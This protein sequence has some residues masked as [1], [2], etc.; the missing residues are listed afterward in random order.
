MSY[1]YNISYVLSQDQNSELLIDFVK[2]DNHVRLYST[3]I[4]LT[5]SVTTFYVGG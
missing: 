5:S 3:T 2:A 1:R 4:Y